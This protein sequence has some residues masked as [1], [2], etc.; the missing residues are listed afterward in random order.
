MK[1][2]KIAGYIPL[3]IT[4]ALMAALPSFAQ[5][6]TESLA[7]KRNRPVEHQTLFYHPD[8]AY[9]MW[10]QFNLIKEA[11]SGNALAQHELGIRYII[12]DGIPADTEKAAY[13]I[14]KAANNGLPGACYNYGILLNNGWGVKWNPFEAFKY[15]LK[16]AQNNMPQAEYFIGLIYTDNLIVKRN[17]SKAYFWVKK[18]AK[19]GFAP[20]KTTLA[21]MSGKI[22]LA[23]IDTSSSTGEPS[24]NK[25]DTANSK[26][27]K[28]LSSNISSKNIASNLG[29]VFIDFNAARDTSTKVSN[30]ILLE[31][32]LHQGN[33]E[34]VKKIKIDVKNDTLIN[35]DTAS[36]KALEQ[37]ADAGS[38][39]ALTLL[40][41]LY[42]LGQFFNKDIVEAAVYFIRAI[43]LDSPRSPLLLWHTTKEQGFYT[44]LKNLVDKNDPRAMFVWYGLYSI[45]FDNQLVETDAVKLL[46]KAASLN[47]IP[48]LNELGLD[49]YTGKYI[50]PD[51]EKA[52]AIWKVSAGLGSSEAKLRLS[53]SNIYSDSGN[54]NYRAAVDSIMKSIKDGSVL[55]QATLAY[56]YQNGLGVDKNL[57]DAVEYYRFA[58]QRGSQFA[59]NQLKQLYDSIRPADKE[60]Q[61][62]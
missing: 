35:V 5:D 31:D 1:E 37:F 28:K 21:D 3:I 16:A 26:V 49:Y 52:I 20:A 54:E 14:G 55:A 48:A 7:F 6:T 27:S 57:P 36:V 40:G 42:E 41:R 56:C 8:I 9:Q 22:D 61:L 12:G 58:A 38:P 53:I 11:N 19:D 24:G 15:F 17:L 59:Y 50:K 39:E 2:I 32:L 10:Q 45:G 33:D 43:K 34:L 30:K 18:S 4:I 46:E 60:F 44:E 29:L 13:W 23:S 25:T 62:N 51:R 47:Y